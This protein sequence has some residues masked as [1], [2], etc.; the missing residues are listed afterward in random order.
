MIK[1]LPLLIGWLL[2]VALLVCAAGALVMV[3][4]NCG[5]TAAFGAP[6]LGYWQSTSLLGLVAIVAGLIKTEVKVNASKS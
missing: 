6:E 1:L 2:L 5:A 4:W 3:L